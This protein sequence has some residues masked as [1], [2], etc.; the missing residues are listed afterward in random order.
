LI[1]IEGIFKWLRGVRRPIAYSWDAYSINVLPKRMCRKS[2]EWKRAAILG[3]PDRDYMLAMTLSDWRP[4]A[5]IFGDVIQRDGLCL[6]WRERGDTDA[7][8][9]PSMFE[10]QLASARR[11]ALSMSALRGEGSLEVDYDLSILAT[12]GRSVNWGFDPYEGIDDGTDAVEKYI[13]EERAKQAVVPLRTDPDDRKSL[14]GN[15][16]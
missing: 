5:S 3:R 13:K 8:R 1:T 4:V 11:G 7:S 16:P 10:R 9:A 12:R 15:A 14:K 6:M 2:L